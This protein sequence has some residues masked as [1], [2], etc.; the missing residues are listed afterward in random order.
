MV[1]WEVY[2]VGSI[3]LYQLI[4]ETWKVGN[5]S[6]NC[7]DLL[8]PQQGSSYEFMF[9]GESLCLSIRF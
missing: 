5:P 1:S 3:M 8:D 7:S 6:L 2:I 4:L 9:V